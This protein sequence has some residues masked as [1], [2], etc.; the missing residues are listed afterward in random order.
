M[1]FSSD[2]KEELSKLNTYSNE[3]SLKLEITGYLI[4]NATLQDNL[5]MFSSENVGLFKYSSGTLYIPLV[6]STV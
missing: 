4:S 5:V 3:D 2:I 6:L 1:S